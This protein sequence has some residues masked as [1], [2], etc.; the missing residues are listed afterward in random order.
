MTSRRLVASPFANNTNPFSLVIGRGPTPRIV[1]IRPWAAALGGT[2]AILLLGWYLAA[3]LY[4]VFRDEMLAR[5]MSQQAEMQY[6]YEDRLAALRNQLDKVTSRQLLD[7]NSL[8]GK[9][10]ELL[11]RQAQLETRQA[12]V[13]AL[14]DQPIFSGQRQAARQAAP[15]TTG[16]IPAFAPQERRPTPAADAF[17]L[18]LP[19][20]RGQ[21]AIGGPEERVDRSDLRDAPAAMAVA[22]ARDAADRMEKRQL[23]ALDA[24][25]A[26]ARSNAQRLSNVFAE[27]G[28]DPHRFA[29]APRAA[30]GGPFLPI[31]ARATG[32]F[33]EKLGQV[34]LTI[35][36]AD[37]MRRIVSGLP[38]ARPMPAEFETTSGFGTRSD[39]FTRGLAM[40]TGI[41]F[42][43]PSG[44]PVKATAAGKIVEADYV[45]GYGNMV[46]VDH[47]A[48]LST[49]Y[50]HLSSI[51]VEIGQTIA[52]GDI[53][54]R[55]GTTGRS[56]GPHLH[57]ETRIDG[58]PA[59]PL[60][61]M[62]AGQRVAGP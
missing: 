14:A 4:L 38:I 21:P 50:A 62:R 28:L 31:G 54:G 19:G 22:S 10:Q 2:A 49:R 48:G 12:V 61:F 40:H 23:A 44:T 7:Q 58:E 52:K 33:A 41:D 34:Q 36:Q 46:E 15:T 1:A 24:L 3:T 26:S 43:A 25:A 59:D 55:V 6:A 60:R 53:L 9:L 30:Q 42:R 20:P 35:Q 8:E 5:L 18:R 45:G 57:Y 32:P 47:G 39:P 17:E 51:G 37:R 16:S 13:A 29:A 11:S 27:T 56:T